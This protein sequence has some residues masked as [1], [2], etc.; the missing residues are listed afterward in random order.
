MPKKTIEDATEVDPNVQ[1][2]VLPD[3][4][5]GRGLVLIDRVVINWCCRHYNKKRLKASM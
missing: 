4:D 5:C 1:G 2:M 3:S